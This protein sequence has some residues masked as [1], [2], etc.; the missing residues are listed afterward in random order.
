MDEKG[1]PRFEGSRIAN[2]VTHCH[3]PSAS[4]QACRRRHG[5]TRVGYSRPSASLRSRGI[6][7][8]GSSYAVR[9]EGPVSEWDTG[10]KMMQ[11]WKLKREIKLAFTRGF[12]REGLASG[13][14]LG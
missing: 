6:T 3:G 7:K 4:W 14:Q 10:L 9:S 13:L 5:R 1:N 12:G 2:A 8:I 11:E